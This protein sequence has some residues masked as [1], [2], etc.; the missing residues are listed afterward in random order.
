MK[1]E[2]VESAWALVAVDS[3]AVLPSYSLR[4]TGQTNLVITCITSVPPNSF[5]AWLHTE[6][7]NP[8]VSGRL[9]ALKA[10]DLNFL[11]DFL[12]AEDQ[13]FGGSI[14]RH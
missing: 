1:S 8:G 12:R 13:Y 14:P 9:S 10:S 4:T 11:S 3:P 2:P 5:H 7:T 6:A